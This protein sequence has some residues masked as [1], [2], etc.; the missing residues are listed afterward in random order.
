MRVPGRCFGQMHVITV[1]YVCTLIFTKCTSVSSSLKIT[2][3]AH[4]AVMVGGQARVKRAFC[5]PP[6]LAWLQLLLR[7][8]DR[9]HA[10]RTAGS[11]THSTPALP[12]QVPGAARRPPPRAADC[13][14][15]LSTRPHAHAWKLCSSMQPAVV[16]PKES[17]G[18]I[19]CVTLEGPGQECHLTAPRQRPTQ[20]LS[21]TFLS[22][23]PE[24]SVFI[25]TRKLNLPHMTQMSLPPPPP[26]SAPWMFYPPPPP[27][28]RKP[29][30]A[31]QSQNGDVQGGPPSTHTGPSS[32]R[33]SSHDGSDASLTVGCVCVLQQAHQALSQGCLAALRACMP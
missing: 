33:V 24:Y 22:F 17:R 7:P 26:T 30:P 3:D 11:H 25:A 8:L 19:R 4:C 28:P 18:K 2:A 15:F 10:Q 31:A 1:P 5:W 14:P 16:Q 27:P 21:Q 9:T 23:P 13:G 6:V 12:A 29:V 32:R 20:S